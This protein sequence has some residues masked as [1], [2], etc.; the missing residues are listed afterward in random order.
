MALQSFGEVVSINDQIENSQYHNDSL[1]FDY[2]LNSK[3]AKS[4]LL[5]KSKR[6]PSEVENKSS[7]NLNFSVGAWLT[8]VLPA[9]RYW[10]EVK[11]EKHAK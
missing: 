5:N 1:T 6:I 10:N 11:G 2:E 3:A 9:V 7:I 4:K 8:A